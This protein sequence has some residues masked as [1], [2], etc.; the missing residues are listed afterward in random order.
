MEMEMDL[1]NNLT[2]L[3]L[4]LHRSK[5]Q[6]TSSS[7]YLQYCTPPTRLWLYVAGP[8]GLYRAFRYCA[9]GRREG[10]FAEL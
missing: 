5:F 1:D 7:P 3:F 6:T 9:L 4:K 10:I 8:Y 2:R